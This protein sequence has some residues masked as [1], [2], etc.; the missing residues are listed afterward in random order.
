MF[1]I[2]VQGPSNEL[3]VEHH[4]I[5]FAMKVKIYYMKPV[6]ERHLKIVEMGSHSKISGC[7]LLFEI[8]SIPGQ[9]YIQ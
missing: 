5:D 2:C 6:N 7:K 4:Y 3:F 1:H 9:P 8:F